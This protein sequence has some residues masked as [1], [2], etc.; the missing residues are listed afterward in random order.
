MESIH[1]SSPSH[2]GA[3]G[4]DQPAELKNNSLPKEKKLISSRRY[5]TRRIGHIYEEY[6]IGELPQNEK[7]PIPSTTDVEQLSEQAPG[8]FNISAGEA[9]EEVSE[10]F[11]KPSI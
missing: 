8:M 10:S 7:S 1:S 11:I 3:T 6:G 4:S 2:T 9:T 5:N